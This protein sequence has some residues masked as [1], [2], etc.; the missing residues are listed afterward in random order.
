VIGAGPM[1]LAVAYQLVKDGFKPVVFEADDRVGGMSASFDFDGLRIE[2]FY[3]FHCTS[4]DAVFQML[5]ELGIKSKL[6]WVETKMGYYYQGG[7]RAW[8]NPLAL[9]FFPGLSLIA[10]IRY[11]FHVFL[12]TK[13]N[14]WQDLDQIYA[15]PWLKRWLGEEAFKILWEKLFEYKFYNYS[16][17]ISAA[18][19]WSR[20]RR[21]GRSRY[22]IFRE[23]YGYIEG[24]SETFLKA[25]KNYVEENGGEIRLSTKVKKIEINKDQVYGVNI[26]NEVE[27]FSKVISTVPIPYVP[28]LIPD[29]PESI[30][31]Q[32]KSV[33]SV[34]VV[35][36]IVKLKKKVT[37]NFWMNV[38]DPNMG[39]PGFVEY[40]NLQPLSQHL[41]YVPYY[42]PADHPKFKEP[43]QVF[44][45]EVK[46][47]LKTI[48]PNLREDDFI[49]MYVNRYLHAQPVCTPGFLNKLPPVSLPTNGL[50]VADTSYYYPEDRGMSESIGFGRDLARKALL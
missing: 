40:T 16:N 17:K 34:A 33:D 3:H 24:G 39:I 36:V 21:V 25:I 15:I 23:K 6:H 47:Y 48:N 44:V 30:I 26:E 38:T 8:G 29:L 18:W 10:K 7:V 50:W 42:L 46:S 5:D 19:I 11:G 31:S 37:E 43:N 32:Y 41:V 35:C 45:D 20:I 12:S 28:K 49:G 22:N 1:G 27:K 2:R 9:L 13:R 4:D 14:N